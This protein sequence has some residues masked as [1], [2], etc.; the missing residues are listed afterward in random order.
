M[1]TNMP[2]P[3][4]CSEPR[5]LPLHNLRDGD[6][7]DI[8]VPEPGQSWFCAGIMPH[9]IG[10]VYD[11]VAHQNDLRTC[12]YTPLKGVITWQ[13]NEGDWEGLAGFYMRAL[14]KARDVRSAAT[15]STSAAPGSGEVTE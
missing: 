13:E 8:R 10:F 2:R 9:S 12:A 14:Q 11:D 3:W 5:C 15:P 1:T 6:Y 4:L 7:R